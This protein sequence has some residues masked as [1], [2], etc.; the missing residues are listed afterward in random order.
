MTPEQITEALRADIVEGR[1][2]PGTLLQQ[3][4]LADRFGVSRIPIRDALFRLSGEQLAHLIPG[5]GA[6]VT[7]LSDQDL[8]EVFALRTLLETDCL[9]RAIRNAAPDWDAEIDHALAVS[10]LEA[11]HSGWRQGDWRF[12]QTLYAPS[13]HS[14]Q[15]RLIAELRNLCALHIAAYDRLTDQTPRWLGN[16]QKIVTACHARDPKAATEA[17]DAHISAVRDQLV[18]KILS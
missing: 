14:R 12:H 6:H 7:Q 11:G 13:G 15:I 18:P 9:T 8:A 3:E 1:L 2:L 10:S 16:H 5:R 4:A 17:L